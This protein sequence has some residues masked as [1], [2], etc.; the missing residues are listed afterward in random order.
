[1][2]ISSSP[3]GV[4]FAPTVCADFTDDGLADAEV[5]LWSLARGEASGDTSL[6]ADV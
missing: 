5:K 3:L 2:A 1:M 6:V 4:A